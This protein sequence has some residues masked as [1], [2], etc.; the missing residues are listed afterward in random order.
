MQPRR[1]VVTGLGAL[2][3]LGNSIDAFWQG[4]A[5]GVSGAD[6]IKQFDAAK[7]KT[8]FACELKN[9]DPTQFMDKKDAR[10]MDPFTQTAVIAADE[11]IADAKIDRN[12]VDVDRVG[13]IWGTG[14]GGM[15]N[16]SHEL[17]EFFAGDGTPR[18]SPFLITRLILDIAAGHISIRHGFRGPNFSV[19][20]ACA[21]STNAIID[22]MYH[23]RWGKA[24]V[25]ITGGSENIINEPCVGG[26][27]AMK[28][29]SER[30][31][32]PKTASRPFD[33]DR[34]GFVM[35]EGAGAL[36]LE[37]YEHAMARGAKIYAEL[38]GGGATADA[39]HISAPHPEGL[40]AFN[41]MKAALN[42]AGMAPEDIDYINV[43]GT[44]T[45]LG[46]V[47]EVK[48]VQQVFG[49]AAYKLNISST[50]SMTGHLLGAAGAVESITII[51]SI[52]EGLVPPTINHFT[53]DP[54]L[55]SKLNFT[56]NVAQKRE[57]RAALSNT[58]GFG[59]HNAS[60]IFKK[61]VP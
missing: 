9:F 19:V 7:F 50:K 20:S 11:A 23:I 37:S 3:P 46:D 29:L 5:N 26:F 13:V 31:D 16:F 47:A 25:I 14:V 44:S 18:F 22:A 17:K 43:H 38:A 57:V 53:D 58:F 45:P 6:F 28:A 4:L 59:G 10:K 54:Q 35:G 2:T 15:I 55:D 21:S 36:V 49:D 8:R 40:G 52:I 39:H 32:D 1:V 60:V 48:A 33:L 12:S 56:F 42:D 30:N 24:D 61:F 27:N 34:D 41:V 51:K